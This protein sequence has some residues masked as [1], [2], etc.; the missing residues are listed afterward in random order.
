[1]MDTMADF[2]GI[3]TTS[4]ASVYV[5]G[6]H[7][8]KW[9]KAGTDVADRID[10]QSAWLVENA[11]L[12]FLPRVEKRMA[13]GYRMELLSALPDFVDEGT[14]VRV[15]VSKLGQL[16]NHPRVHH[17]DVDLHHDYVWTRASQV[18]LAKE[19]EDWGKEVLWYATRSWYAV[20]HVHGDPTIDNCMLRSSGELVITDPIP[21]GV[22]LPSIRALDIGKILQSAMGY[23]GIRFGRRPTNMPEVP[24]SYWEEVLPD[25]D[26]DEWNL[27]MYL[28]AV[29]FVRLLRYTPQHL[30]AWKDRVEDLMEMGRN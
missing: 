21:P 23:E 18:G 1:M 24:S 8:I 14:L 20:C 7:V 25:V 12:D 27:C 6:A 17:F 28:A 26:S 15:M 2:P 30:E 9:A 22:H 11:K 3:E 4:G 16:W 19:M 5:H 29:H 10:M 13:G